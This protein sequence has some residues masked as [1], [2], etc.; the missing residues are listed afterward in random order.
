MPT[1][2]PFIMVVT[3]KPECSG[4][5]HDKCE[6]DIIAT[7]FTNMDD[8]RDEASAYDVDRNEWVAAE[9]DVDSL[10]R[11]VAGDDT[12]FVVSQDR[13]DERTAV[14]IRAL[15]SGRHADALLDVA[16]RGGWPMYGQAPDPKT[17]IV[18]NKN[19]KGE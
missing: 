2:F 3:L 8:L 1:T 18:G 16:Q 10:I 12:W 7:E 19:R 14:N 9:G 13:W 17:M 15:F 4:P 5:D 11:Q 6:G